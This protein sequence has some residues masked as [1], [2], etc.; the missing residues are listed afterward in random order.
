MAVALQVSL[1]HLDPVFFRFRG[2]KL[3]RDHTQSAVIKKIAA[4]SNNAPITVHS[5]LTKCFVGG[6]VPAILASKSLSPSNE[7]HL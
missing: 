1:S 2:S 7:K 6:S 3:R 4:A 5:L